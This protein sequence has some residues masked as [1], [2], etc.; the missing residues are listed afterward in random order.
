MNILFRCQS[1]DAL[2]EFRLESGGERGQCVSCGCD[3]VKPFFFTSGFSGKKPK[4]SWFIRFLGLFNARFAKKLQSFYRRRHEEKQQI[5]HC[6]ERLHKSDL[7][8]LQYLETA[9]K[10]EQQD[11]H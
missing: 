4:I 11:E 3:L 2:M 8:A 7:Q 10:M 6:Q 1:C 9:I 5:Q